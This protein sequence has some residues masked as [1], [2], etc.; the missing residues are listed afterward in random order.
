MKIF[1]NVILLLILVLVHISFASCTKSKKTVHTS[2]NSS[3]HIKKDTVDKSTEVWEEV[4]RTS[5]KIEPNESVPMPKKQ[6][7]EIR[8]NENR[9]EVRQNP[10]KDTAITQ[11]ISDSLSFT[12]GKKSIILDAGESLEIV[13]YLKNNGNVKEE[14]V[15]LDISGFEGKGILKSNENLS[16]RIG[17][18]LPGQKEKVIFPIKINSEIEDRTLFLKIFMVK[19]K[20]DKSS[21]LKIKVTCRSREERMYADIIKKSR[22]NNESCIAKCVEYIEKYR[23]GLYTTKIKNLLENLRWVKVQ[24]IYQ[25]AVTKKNVEQDASTEIE[26]TYLAYYGLG[27]R[28]SKD[29]ARMFYE[30]RDF[31]KACALDTYE[32]YK[33]FKEKYKKSPFFRVV[34]ARGTLAYWEQKEK[35][36]MGNSHIW[37][38]VAQALVEEKGDVGCREA[39]E[40]FV[41]TIQKT[42]GKK[43]A[44]IG[45]GKILVAWRNYEECIEYLERKRP[46]EIKHYKIDYYVGYAY[47][48][49]E[50]YNKAI[51]YYSRAIKSLEAGISTIESLEKQSDY[52]ECL[53]Y[54]ALLYRTFL[55]IRKA[56]KDFEK[57]IELAPESQRAAD[58]KIYLKE[59]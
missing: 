19:G 35:K 2:P 3:K 39:K 43:E 50:N 46:K 13:V 48:Q 11:K 29:A 10:G 14:D 51:S 47:E 22:I 9:Q 26:S 12:T 59:I 41:K 32:E 5:K 42:P 17:V 37:C 24:R 21:V 34:A 4:G 28:Y 31:Q 6:K 30:L 44:Y 27:G 18:I 58:A 57:I 1:T 16:K 55:Y 7:M 56:K 15:K 54:R 25:Q 45:I 40:Y 36:D 33:K 53:Y 49:L 20:S 23:N 38:Q 52:L 8:D